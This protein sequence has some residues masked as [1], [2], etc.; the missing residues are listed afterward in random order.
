MSGLSEFSKDL[1]NTVPSAQHF[2]ALPALWLSPSLYELTCSL[3]PSIQ[4]CP[5]FL[6]AFPPTQYMHAWGIYKSKDYTQMVLTC[7]LKKGKSCQTHPPLTGLYEPI[8][9]SW[10]LPHTHPSKVT[11]SPPGY[12]CRSPK[13]ELQHATTHQPGQN[14]I[15]TLESRARQLYSYLLSKANIALMSQ[16]LCHP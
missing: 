12:H 6:L 14:I 11:D 1:W 9:V 3:C 15:Y 7:F 13:E 4:M 10:K 8:P 16:R 2:L 5:S